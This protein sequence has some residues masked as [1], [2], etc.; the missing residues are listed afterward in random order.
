MDNEELLRR[1]KMVRKPKQTRTAKD[2]LS[3]GS[4]LL[5]CA[6]TGS[7]FWGFGKG[8]YVFLVGDSMS[9]K[10]WLSLTMFAEASRRRAFKDYQFIFDQPEAGALMDIEFFFGKR[11][12]R[13]LGDPLNGI[14]RTTQEFYFNITDAM[15]RGPCL[16]VLDSMDALNDIDDVQQF[17]KMK[18]AHKSGKD[19]S[20]SYGTGK[21]RTNSQGLRL[22]MDMLQQTG[23]IL[24][25]ISQ[26]RENIGFGA[27][28]N[29]KTRSGGKA[30]R[31]YANV[32]VWTSVIGQLKKTVKKKERSIGSMVRADI[33][34]NRHNGQ[35]HKIAIPIYTSY[36]MDNTGSCVDFLVDEGHWSKPKLTIDAHDL[37]L[38]GTRDNL[39]GSIE[40]NDME[41]VTAEIVGEVW[42]E[43]I[44]ESRLDR[45]AR[46]T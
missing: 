19:S 23:S 32:E 1:L 17:E 42:N 38:T 24:L 46:Y 39:I 11:A 16:Y 30:L 29:P 45:K 7:P 21:A 43:I 28:F 13:R 8:D 22:V 31:F 35:K 5:N 10:T 44:D 12:A 14:S 27:Q 36:G 9:G 34:K 18:K 40:D 37:E 41:T 4:T 2:Y 25:I 15:E 33:I 3:T 20:G 26:T 6:L